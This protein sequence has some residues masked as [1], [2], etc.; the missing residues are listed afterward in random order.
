MP[1]PIGSTAC[2]HDHA[3]LIRLGKREV[4]GRRLYM[5]LCTACGFQVST[6]ELR[7]L[8]AHPP[9][10]PPAPCGYGAAHLRAGLPWRRGLRL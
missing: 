10:R 2:R 3:P 1:A 8:R 9:R 7:R 4:G 5:L 6:D